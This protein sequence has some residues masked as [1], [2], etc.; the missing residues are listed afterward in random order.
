MILSDLI[1]VCNYVKIELHSSYN[2]KLIAS[3]KKSLEKYSSVQV[4]GIIPK[5][6]LNNDG[7]YCG[8]YL[9][10]YVSPYEIDKVNKEK[11]Y[12]CIKSV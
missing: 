5:M 1:S 2:G 3:S 6:K 12:E 10:V 9:Y 4:K 11:N 8:S 7:T